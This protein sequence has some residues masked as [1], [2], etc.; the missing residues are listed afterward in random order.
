MVVT[1]GIA[2]PH[3][4]FALST[5]DDKDL[6]YLNSEPLENTSMRWKKYFLEKKIPV[7][8]VHFMKQV[9]GND[10]DEIDHETQNLVSQNV[11]ALITQDAGVFVGVKSADCLPVMLFDPRHKTVAAVHAG[12]R[13]T[14]KQ[15]VKRVL[16]RF[17]ELGS[18]PEDIH[19][20]LCPAIGKCCYNV[21]E[22]RDGRIEA[23]EK[24]F[25]SS[26]ISER[27]GKKFLDI[28][29]ANKKMLQDLKIPQGQIVDIN[30]CTS[31]GVM[32]LPSYYKDKTEQRF[33][34][35]IGMI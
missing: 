35:I 14:E 16:N 10:F 27:N 13:G 34:S 22:S 12:W 3:I 4:S 19:A 5:L 7:S 26:G 17:F 6:W 25:G 15:I 18:K 11:D 2:F 32:H 33:I 21:T 23:F 20:I 31:C 29:G 1:R 24:L 28:R 9:H 8:S 30:E